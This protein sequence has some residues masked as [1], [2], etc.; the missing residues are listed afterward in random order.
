METVSSSSEARIETSNRPD[1]WPV[2]IQTWT[3]VLFLHWPIDALEL[4]KHLPDGVAIDRWGG[5]AWITL[6]PLQIYNVR[7]PYTPPIPYLSELNELNLRTYVSMDGVPGV[8]FF[9][10]DANHLL[11]VLAANALF[12]LPYF[13]SDIDVDRQENGAM[14]FT[15]VRRSHKR[16]LKARWSSDGAYAPAE[17]D[18]A[19]HFLVERYC[20]YTESSGNLYRARIHHHPWQLSPISDLDLKTDLLDD[21]GLSSTSSNPKLTHAADTVT[22]EI[23]PLEKVA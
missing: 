9:S 10:L 22:V 11:A 14:N 3:N 12:S 20:L 23:W 15:S 8:W 6:T 21:F 17:I 13:Y 4:K 2:N 1:G 16:S 19:E 7:L 5:A 18:S